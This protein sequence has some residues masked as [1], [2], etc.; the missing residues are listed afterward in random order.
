MYR[1]D[2]C[3]VGCITFYLPRERLIHTEAKEILR[4]KP[5]ELPR[6]PREILFPKVGSGSYNPLHS[7]QSILYYA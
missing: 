3:V 6:L 2:H 4:V 1:I 7:D 5:K